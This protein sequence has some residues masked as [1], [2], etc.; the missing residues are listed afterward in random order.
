M[1]GPNLSHQQKPLRLRSAV[2]AVSAGAVVVVAGSVAAVE[3]SAT[4]VAAADSAGEAGLVGTAVASAVVTVVEVEVD[5]VEVSYHHSFAP[6]R[7]SRRMLLRAVVCREEGGISSSF[8]DF[9]SDSSRMLF[10]W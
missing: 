5:S 9:D 1:A 10:S 7:T 3:G 4:V 8:S 2:V 6:S